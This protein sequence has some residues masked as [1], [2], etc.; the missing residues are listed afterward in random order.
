MKKLSSI[1]TFAK[2]LWYAAIMLFFA[3]CTAA[4]NLQYAIVQNPITGRSRGKCGGLVFSTMFGENVL[5]TKALT[6]HNPKTLL[7]QTQRARFSLML[8]FL[9]P[10]LSVLKTGFREMAIHKSAFNAAMSFNVMNAI[11]GTYP[12]FEIFYGNLLVSK[13]SLFGFDSPAAAA[14]AGKLINFT[15]DSSNIGGNANATDVFG[16]C[17]IDNT[18]KEAYYGITN[19]DRPVEHAEVTLPASTVG[20]TVDC[21]M[22]FVATVNKK[23]STSHWA[24]GKVVLN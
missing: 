4:A 6:V 23:V 8:G 14:A 24:G 15:W 17:I 16:Y 5:K 3:V 7:Q 1:S 12:D 21:Y 2:S 9:K 18:T 13:G 11:S 20:H 22:F 10:M 19:V